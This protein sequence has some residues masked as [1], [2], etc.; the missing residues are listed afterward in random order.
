MGEFSFEE[1]NIGV[2]IQGFW[3]AGDGVKSPQ[4]DSVKDRAE[5]W[6]AKID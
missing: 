3:G 5:V 4:G 2:G 6:F 1:G